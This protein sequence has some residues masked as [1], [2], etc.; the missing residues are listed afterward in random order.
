MQ[1]EQTIV[2]S[3]LHF[4]FFTWLVLWAVREP[5]PPPLAGSGV[6]Y[7]PARGSKVYR[8]LS[9]DV[10][11]EYV[12]GLDFTWHEFTST[13]LFLHVAKSFAQQPAPFTIFEITLTTR[14]AC[15][16]SQFSAY[17]T[18]EEVL[19]PPGSRFVVRAVTVDAYDPY[20]TRI[21][22]EELSAYEA[23]LEY[24]DVRAWSI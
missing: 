11:A 20:E 23:I 17:P 14:W 3:L 12:V 5:V 15:R 19:L 18:E 6:D 16:V 10:R 1:I 4:F 21:I 13:S 7:A 2:K 22:L 8:G 9:Q 24:G